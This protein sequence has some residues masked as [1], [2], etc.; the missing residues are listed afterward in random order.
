MVYKGLKLRHEYKYYLPYADYLAMRHR[1][2]SFMKPDGHMGRDGYHVRSLYF[3]DALLTA[4]FDKVSGYKSRNKTRIRVY[5]RSM[6]LI[7]LERKIKIMGLVGKRTAVINQHQLDYFLSGDARV[8]LA[9]AHPVIQR[10]YAEMKLNRLRPAVMVDYRR[11]AYVYKPGN[12]RITF[13]HDLQAVT[14]R[15]DC[16]FSEQH[17]MYTNVYPAGM[18]VMEVKFDDF[19]PDAV[20][21]LIKPYTARRSAVSKYVLAL[22]AAGIGDTY[23]GSPRP[24]FYTDHDHDLAPS[25]CYYDTGYY[26]G[27]IHFLH[28]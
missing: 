1:I 22:D 19:L 6:D 7:R 13:D 12:V 24:T 17:L 9:S 28:L 2:A 11:E 10:F 21:R 27:A 18:L 26:R 4:R 16:H 14:G 23:G 20:K 5:N 8:L 25:Y 3:D 15:F